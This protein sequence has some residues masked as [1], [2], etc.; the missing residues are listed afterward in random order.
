MSG[1][2]RATRLTAR[3]VEVLALA[4]IGRS[5]RRIA[6]RLAI[7]C[8]A[9]EKHLQRC[10]ARREQPSECGLRSG[11]PQRI[12][13]LLARV[14]VELG[15][16]AP[17]VRVYGEQGRGTAKTHELLSPVARELRTI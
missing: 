13:E 7:S 4:C 14:D 1:S 10:Y 15:E 8:R 5:D 16:S 11:S 3:E 2:L 17:E 12:G 9:V 6:E